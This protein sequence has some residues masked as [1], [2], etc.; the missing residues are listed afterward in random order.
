MGKKKVKEYLKIALTDLLHRADAVRKNYAGNRIE[1][2]GIVNAKS[3]L[4]GEDCKFCAQSAHNGADT[5]VYP[6]KPEEEIVNAARKAETEGA[7]RFGIVTSGNRLDEKEIAMIGGA[8]EK[9]K[10]KTNL[11]VCASMGALDEKSMV[12]LK[13]AGLTRYHHNLETSERYYS[14]IVTTHNYRER[15]NT[16]KSALDAGLEVCSGGILGMGETWDDRIDM[17]LLLKDLGV[18]SIPLNFLVPVKGTFFAER[19]AISPIEALR[20]IALFRMILPDK[21]IK[22]AA[23]R[24]SVLNDFQGMLY[25]AGANGMMI[26][27]YLTVKGRCPEEDLKLVKAVRELWNSD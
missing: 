2:C 3:G 17:A 1:L 6:L 22:I 10:S 5:P 12:F 26:G 13:K 9:I 25:S 21:D 14:F 18:N 27:G 4:C 7:A 20:A 24:E 15:V 11:S 16:I 23:G 8:I 19:E